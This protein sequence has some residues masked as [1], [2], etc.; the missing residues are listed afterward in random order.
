MSSQP[1][2][3]PNDRAKEIARREAVRAFSNLKKEMRASLFDCSG[4]QAD[5]LRERIDATHDPNALFFL[6]PDLYSVISISCGENIAK[7]RLTSV[8]PLF[9]GL[10]QPSLIKAAIDREA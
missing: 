10:I 9:S 2:Y 4:E 6:R 1:H 8:L 7:S 3:A 5:R